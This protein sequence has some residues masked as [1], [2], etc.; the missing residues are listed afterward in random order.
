VR[1]GRGELRSLGVIRVAEVKALRI[2][3]EEALAAT[4]L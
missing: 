1:E 4:L 2:I 3:L